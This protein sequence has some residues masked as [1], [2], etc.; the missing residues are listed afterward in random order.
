M[1]MQTTTTEEEQQQA[2]ERQERNVFLLMAIGFTI[3]LCFPDDPRYFE[4]VSPSGKWNS[5]GTPDKEKCWTFAPDL[6]SREAACY[7]EDLAA[8][9]YEVFFYQTPIKDGKYEQGKLGDWFCRV[10]HISQE[11]L[12]FKATASTR[13]EAFLSAAYAA[14]K[15][16]E[17]AAAGENKTP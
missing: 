7:R 15:S 2:Q 6:S 1:Q 4:L 17:Q 9:F 3:R 5:E 13:I 12:S 10:A 8:L 11:H 16:L 14:L